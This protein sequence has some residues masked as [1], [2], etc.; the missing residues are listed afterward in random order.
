MFMEGK[1]MKNL[2]EHKGYQAELCVDA[3]ENIM[4]GRVINI[5]RDVL[6]FFRGGLAQAGK[7]EFLSRTWCPLR[8]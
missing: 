2:I 4:H 3:E 8:L 1:L 5:E 7:R 6:S